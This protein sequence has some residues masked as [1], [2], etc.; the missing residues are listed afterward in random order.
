MTAPTTLHQAHIAFIGGGNMASA[1]IAGLMDAGIPSSHIRVLEIQ[2]ESR[3]TLNERYGIVASANADEVLLNANVLIFS[4]KPQQLASI[5]RDLADKVSDCMIMSIAAGVRTSDLSRWL[6]GKRNIVR[7]MPNTPALVRAGITG[8]F[9]CAEVEESGKAIA[10]Q[11]LEAVG[12]VVWV[13]KE[14]ELDAVTAISG[15]GPA[16]VFH[17]L[18]GL[19]AAGHQLGLSPH[20]SRELA[21]QTLVGAAK[22]AAGSED[23]PTLLRTKV[24]SPGGTT[25][26]ALEVFAQAQWI[27]TIATAAWAAERRAQ[28]LGDSLSQ[29]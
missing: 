18:E 19:I 10:Q 23:S 15:S 26:A 22:L 6:N 2:P 24:T 14:Q 27:E 29:A 7:A 21:L 17:F 28:E 12:T 20:V 9:A 3:K 16:Y 11:L 5:C 4:V 8:L 13:E 25:Q 1:L